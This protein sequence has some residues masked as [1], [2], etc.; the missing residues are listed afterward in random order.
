MLE[1]LGSH[2]ASR[3]VQS[4]ES[5]LFPEEEKAPPTLTS[6]RASLPTHVVGIVTDARAIFYTWTSLCPNMQCFLTRTHLA[7]SLNWSSEISWPDSNRE[8][9]LSFSRWQAA[10]GKPRDEA[11]ERCWCYR[12]CCESYYPREASSSGAT[13]SITLSRPLQRSWL[14]VTP[15]SQSQLSSR[16]L[17][18]FVTPS[19]LTFS[20]IS[21]TWHGSPEAGCSFLPQP[22]PHWAPWGESPPPTPS[23][24]KRSQE[25]LG[26]WANHQFGRQVTWVYL[27]LPS[28]AL[29][30]LESVFSYL[31]MG[32]ITLGLPQRSVLKIK[33]SSW[34]QESVKGISG[35]FPEQ[36]RIR[37]DQRLRQSFIGQRAHLFFFFFFRIFTKFK[38]D[39]DKVCYQVTWWPI[40]H[41]WNLPHDCRGP[42]YECQVPEERPWES[43]NS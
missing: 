13:A 18:Q 3:D 41:A 4:R 28:K 29:N 19:L 9:F 10:F 17:H 25:Q 24:H 6:L 35:G 38:G 27:P 20:V 39:D 16:A 31:Q 40:V 23:S 8:G 1:G 43:I 11:R 34:L 33:R 32:M 12:V 5:T 7:R 30:C 21:L 2:Q 15:W 42:Q 37:R 26:G 22:C 14:P 36:N